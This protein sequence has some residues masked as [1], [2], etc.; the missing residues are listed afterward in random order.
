MIRDPR[1]HGRRHADRAVNPAEVIEG[2]VKRQ[3]SPVV[4][5]LAA[6]TIR[7]SRE[8]ADV[9]PHGQVLAFNMG[10]A[11]SFRIGI[12]D[13]WHFLRGDNFRR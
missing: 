13:H 3:G 6:K 10:S 4:L 11:D 9:R 12:A 2:E 7:Q 8:S 1:F 5:K